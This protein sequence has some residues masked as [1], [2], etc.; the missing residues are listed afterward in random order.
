M[1]T[2]IAAVVFAWSKRDTSTSSVRL[3]DEGT[4][5]VVASSRFRRELRSD[6]RSLIPARPL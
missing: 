2:A 5:S 4:L 6:W 3:V 1:H